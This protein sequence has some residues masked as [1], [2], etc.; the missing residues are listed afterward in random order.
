MSKALKI[1]VVTPSFNSIHT[2]RATIASVAAQDYPNLEHLVVDGEKMSK[3]KGNFYTLPDLIERGASPRTI[4]YLLLSVPYR[5]KLNFT[6]DALGAAS[7]ALERLESLDRRLAERERDIGHVAH[8]GRREGRG[9]DLLLLLARQAPQA[10]KPAGP[11]RRARRRGQGAAQRLIQRQ[12]IE[13]R[14]FNAVELAGRI[15]RA[16]LHHPPDALPAQEF[17]L[18]RQELATSPKRE[19]ELTCLAW[20]AAAVQNYKTAGMNFADAL[21]CAFDDDSLAP[22]RDYIARLEVTPCY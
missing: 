14:R 5:Q 17:Q 6:F 16:G 12:V 2:I 8:E 1:S 9:G 15:D 7:S 11:H 4:R 13:R 20:A 21:R 18:V 3:S 22:A 19:Q 10:P